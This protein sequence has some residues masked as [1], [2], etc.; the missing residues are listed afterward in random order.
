MSFI[1]DPRKFQLKCQ[2]GE[3]TYPM[4]LKIGNKVLSCRSSTI[5]SPGK[6]QHLAIHRTNYGC[7]RQNAILKK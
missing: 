4:T 6:G 1:Y 7:S 5:I 2:G 3:K